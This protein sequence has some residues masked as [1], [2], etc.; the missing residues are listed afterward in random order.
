[1]GLYKRIA[2]IE[3]EEDRKDIVDEVIDRFGDPPK[4]MLDLLTVSLVRSAAIRCGVVNI[5]EEDRAVRIYPS[6]ID[7]DV[8]AVLSYGVKFKGRVR[9]IG[10][11]NVCVMINKKSGEDVLTLLLSLFNDFIRIRD[12]IEQQDE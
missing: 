7:Y 6:K 4:P 10:T 12:E 8:W 11:E 1:M 9:M 5:V 3:T 2:M